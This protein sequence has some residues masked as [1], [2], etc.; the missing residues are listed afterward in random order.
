MI[1]GRAHPLLITMP[2]ALSFG[3]RHVVTTESG[4]KE[5]GML[6]KYPMKHGVATYE[7]L[8]EL[9]EVVLAHLAH[10]NVFACILPKTTNLLKL[11]IDHDVPSLSDEAKYQVLTT[12]A[13]DTVTKLFGARGCFNIYADQNTIV[14]GIINIPFEIATSSMID[15]FSARNDEPFFCLVDVEI[16]LHAILVSHDETTISIDMQI[17]RVTHG[18]N[19]LPLR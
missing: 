19:I 1:D 15:E 3:L 6:L 14:I 4:Y 12:R 7:S 9:H 16:G 18:A 5:Y 10:P 11:Q 13:A 2:R 8:C 17:D